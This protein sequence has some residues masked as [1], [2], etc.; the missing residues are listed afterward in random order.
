MTAGYTPSY[1]QFIH[2][3]FFKYEKSYWVKRVV[4]RFARINEY[5][6]DTFCITIIDMVKKPSSATEKY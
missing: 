6:Y 5:K 2:V 3:R 4:H 1:T